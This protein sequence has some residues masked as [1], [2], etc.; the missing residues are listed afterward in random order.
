MGMDTSSGVDTPASDDEIDEIASEF[1]N[2]DFMPADLATIRKS[3]RRSPRKIVSGS[4][5]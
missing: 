1:E 4:V 5:D 2:R 3:R